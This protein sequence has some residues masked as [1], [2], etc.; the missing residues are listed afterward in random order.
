MS[1]LLGLRLT[2]AGGRESLQRIVFAAVGVGVGTT[3]LLL[4]L[5]GPF[6]MY[7]RDVRGGWQSA[8]YAFNPEFGMPDPPIESAHGALFLAVSDYFDGELMTRTYIA[9]L[10]ADPPV[11]PGLDR[12]PGPG[13]VA[14]SPAMRRLLEV[15]PDDELDDRFPGQ[16]TMTI[17]DAGVTH[18]DERVAIIGRTPDQLRG[19]RSVQEVWGFDVRWN[20]FYF[21]FGGG[22]LT[23]SVFLFATIVVFI[24][25]V[26]RVAAAQRERRLA[27]IR[28]AGATRLQTAIVAATETGVGALAGSLLAWVAYEVG[29]RVLAATVT[30]D[31]GPFFLE[32]VAVPPR[33][34]VLVL[35]GMPV[36]AMLITVA[37]LRR[38]QVDPLSVSRRG[39][40]RSPSVWMALPLAVGVAGR[41]L[42]D[43]LE[44]VVSDAMLNRL[45]ALF[46]LLLLG[47][48]VLIGPWLCL[49]VGRGL[50]RVSRTV[51]G[52]IAARRIAADPWATFRAISGVVLAAM[53]V[54]YLGSTAGQFE[55]RTE[56][57]GGGTRLRPGVV[58]VNTGGVS[59]ARVAPLLSEQ[60]VVAGFGMRGLAVPCADLS[61]WSRCRARTPGRPGRSSRRPIRV[62]RES[63]SGSTSRPMARW[64]PRTAYAPRSPTSCRMRSSTPT[65]TCASATSSSPTDVARLA[66][67]GCLFMLL[68]GALSLTAGMIAGLLE[69]RRPFALL[70]A[71][72]VRIGELRWVVFLETAATMVF[73][74]ALGVGMG[75]VTAYV[76]AS[77]GEGDWKR[78][79]LTVFAFVASGILAALLFSALALPLLGATTRHESVRYE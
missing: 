30:F 21:F 52:L 14:V 65:G 58:E 68:V 11:P 5:T 51:P 7:G 79:E 27:T 42:L 6:A 40:R 77:Q 44:H 69:R 28:L 50:A 16:V 78:P 20:G 49:L 63:S 71:S 55:T 41:L 19:V 57:G 73:T 67:I 54:A 25:V 22:L 17:G 18:P 2:L 59:A 29:R 48:F 9:A 12:L 39:F 24:F 46:A 47:G 45:T 34:L 60:T 53:V 43:P 13:E 4:A 31:G 8:A 66:S 1:L 74:S 35:I 23:G 37:S 62:A 3:L 64:P 26:T 75:L 70:R 10:G 32:D 15:T 56:A 38:V 76:A 61:R 72:G 36:V 33:I